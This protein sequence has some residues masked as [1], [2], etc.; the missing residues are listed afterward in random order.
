MAPGQRQRQLFYIKKDQKKNNAKKASKY[1]FQKIEFPVIGLK[2]IKIEQFDVFVLVSFFSSWNTG[3][4][5]FLSR[6]QSNDSFL[7]VKTLILHFYY[8]IFFKE[9][10]NLRISASFIPDQKLLSIY[11][12]PQDFAPLYG[13][14]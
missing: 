11:S 12:F 8:Q 3:F 1:V 2:K 14:T 6:K 13:A 5:R 9:S 7:H 4:S 10:K